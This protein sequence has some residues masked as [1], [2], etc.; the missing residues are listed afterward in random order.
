MEYIFVLAMVGLAA[1][2]V[3]GGLFFS[4]LVAPHNPGGNKSVPY[5]CGEQPI[6]Q[7]WIQFNVG[8]YLFGLLFLVFDVEAALMYPWAVVFRSTGLPGLIEMLI[9]V[10]VLVIG[11]IYAWRKGVLEWV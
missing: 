10:L 1:A 5:E 9:F 11:L 4:R 7:A 6:G 8:Y 3:G 2:M